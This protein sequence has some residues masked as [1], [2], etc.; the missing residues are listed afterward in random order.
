MKA[1]LLLL[2][3]LPFVSLVQNMN[4]QTICSKEEKMCPAT[5]NPKT[6][7]EVTPEYCMPMTDDN[8]YSCDRGSNRDICPIFSKISLQQ[9]FLFTKIGIAILTY[10]IISTCLMSILL[11]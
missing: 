7:E 10:H 3:S 1:Y 2:T 6:G 4:P 8:I 5:M 9:L 11:K